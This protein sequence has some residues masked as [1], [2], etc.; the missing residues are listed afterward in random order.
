MQANWSDATRWT[1][2]GA[3]PPTG[4]IAGLAAY[5]DV[6]GTGLWAIPLPGHTRGHT[7]YAIETGDG[8]L[9]IHAGDA[10]YNAAQLVHGGVVPRGIRIFERL[11]AA[12]PGL[13]AG[14]HERL[15]AANREPGV[16]VVCS[17]DP[18]LITK[19]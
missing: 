7:G 5:D 10:F 4:E 3:E 17:H 6:G 13:T 2:F 11:A 18:A 12:K 14:N 8:E 19:A 9:L 15:V 16:T 1:P